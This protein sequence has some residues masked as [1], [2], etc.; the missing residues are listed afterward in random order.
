MIVFDRTA[1]AADTIQ[2]DLELPVGAP[3]DTSLAAAQRFVRAARSIDEQL[4]GTS[5]ESIGLMVGILGGVAASRTGEDRSIRSRLASVRLKLHERPLRQASPE[6][7][8]R[9]WRQNVGDTP[10]LEKISIQ[11]TRVRFKPSVAYALVH[12]DSETLEKAAGDLKSFMGTVP[13]LYALSDSLS[14]GKR[15]FEI[16]LTPAMIG[17]RLRANFHGVEV[18]RIQRGREEIR[19][20]VR[21][22]PERRRCLREL[23]SERIAGPG[24]Y[25]IPLLTAARVTERRELATLTRIDGKQAA[26]VNAHADLDRITPVQA[27]RKIAKEF[28][29]GLKA[30]YPGLAVSRDAGAREERAMLETLGVPVP[31]VLILI[32][33]LLAGLLRSYWKPLVPFVVSMLGG[34]V[35]AG[36]FTLFVLPALVMLVEGRR[37]A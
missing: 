15:H 37:E 32:Y 22:P 18:H 25:E 4:E 27:R 9:V 11:T 24:G 23:A 16:G 1:N 14:L 30:K 12:D 33:G 20:V 3:F 29:P 2:A 5:I 31:I 13:G 35:A 10:D 28:L 6:A 17:K 8:E 19:V 36:A 34:L 26:L 21:Y 7:I